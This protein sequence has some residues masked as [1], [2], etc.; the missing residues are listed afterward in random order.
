[1]R[2][3][4]RNESKGAVWEAQGAGVAIAEQSA[5]GDALG[6]ALEGVSGASVLT[7]PDDPSEDFFT[8]TE[9]VIAAIVE[10]ARRTCAS[11]GSVNHGWKLP[12]SENH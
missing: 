4:V 9:Q 12:L 3:A 6:R 1:V 2:V 5:E 10:A 8:R 7:P 11:P